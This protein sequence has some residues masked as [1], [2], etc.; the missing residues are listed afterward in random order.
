MCP[1]IPEPPESNCRC[2]GRV[3]EDVLATRVR[4]RTA[5][6]RQQRGRQHTHCKPPAATVSFHSLG[7]RRT[8]KTRVLPNETN[9]HG[10]RVGDSLL[11][12]LVA[13]MTGSQQCNSVPRSLQ[14]ASSRNT[15]EFITRPSI[16]SLRL[17]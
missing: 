13:D 11:S 6:N 17:V 8:N 15:S 3:H 9:R 12:R 7:A 14:L 1:A 16:D 2:R 4:R 5:T 10:G